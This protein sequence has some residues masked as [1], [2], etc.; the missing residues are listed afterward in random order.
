M[1]RFNMWLREFSLSQ[2]LLTIIF[3]FVAVFAGFIFVFIAPAIQNFSETEMFRIL[4]NEQAGI[5][6]YLEDHPGGIPDMG[7]SRVYQVSSYIYDKDTGSFIALGGT[8]LPDM[9]REDVILHTASEASGTSDYS[10]E[11]EDSSSSN[12]DKYL[13]SMIELKDG[14]W[15]V[16]AM[17]DAYRAQFSTSLT[18]GVVMINVLFV[19]ALFVLL[20][21]WVG[22]IIIP[23]NQIKSYVEKIKYDQPAELNIKRNDEIGDVADAIVQMNHELAQQNRE[24]QAMIQNISHD[25][26]TPIATIKSYS[27]A[28][29]D[30]I[31]PYET[32]EKSVDVII[33]HADRLEK[34]VRSLIL[35]N[36]MDYLKDTL[37][38][39]ENLLMAP[40][41][42]KVLLSLKVV[43]PEI[44]FERKLDDK[45][46]FHGEEEPW[47]IVIENLVD[48]AL[49]Y[50][51]TKISIELTE[52]NLRVIND[53]PPV[54]E[55]R[56]DS[57]FKPYEKGTGGQFGPGLSIVH[58]VC[59]T[60]GYIVCAE[61]LPQGVCFH[62]WTD[63]RKPRK[64][65]R[66]KAK[67]A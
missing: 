3:I 55:D 44:T 43:R 36:K 39:G 28:I 56:L 49:R 51:K 35:L 2:Q 34:K 37:P 65:V 52:G 41:V 6:E 16:C 40:I 9:V 38:E 63:R 64:R 27:E 10:V 53:G 14:R 47:R 15:L 11:V 19:S 25:L 48:N 31:Y 18:N 50:A 60:Y 42:D 17:G 13:Y 24:K 29:K 7:E 1:K 59:T 67:E 54:E 32:L 22:S 5:I 66:T 57:L 30:G 4:H 45:V 20:M 12:L 61:N 23:L 46:R 8:T 33:E 62:I 21:I 26:K 58:Q